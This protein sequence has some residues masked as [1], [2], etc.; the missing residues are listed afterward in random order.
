MLQR[1]VDPWDLDS[2]TELLSSLLGVEPALIRQALESGLKEDW[3]KVLAAL[4]PATAGQKLILEAMETGDWTK[5]MK[6]SNEA[7]RQ[8]SETPVQT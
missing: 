8:H 1:F 7:L 3:D 6:A 4:P 2:R 5:V